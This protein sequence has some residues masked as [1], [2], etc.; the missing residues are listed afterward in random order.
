VGRLDRTSEGLVLITNDGE[1]AFRLAHP[2]F[3]IEKTYLVRVAGRPTRESL[4][5]LCK[6]VHLAEGVARV[7]RYRVRRTRT[8]D[9]EL[10][11][12]LNEGKNREIRRVLARLGHKVLTLRRIAFGAI[13]L[14]NLPPGGVRPL[15]ADEVRS[16]TGPQPASERGQPRARR[17]RNAATSGPRRPAQA[18]RQGTVIGGGSPS[19]PTGGGGA[20]RPKPRGGRS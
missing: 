13:R 15:T 10:E 11:L 18:G 7:A 16:L 19:R 4:D 6:G 9:T 20:R 8:Q 3:G 12:V 5:R 14:G 1:L 17:T 2:R